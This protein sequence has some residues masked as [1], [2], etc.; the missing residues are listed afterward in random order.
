MEGI[1]P[2]TVRSFV[3]EYGSIG[4]AH[5]VAI[6]YN[7]T[8]KAG[9]MVIADFLLSPA[10]QARKGDEA[11]WGAPT[12]LAYDKLSTQDQALFDAAISGP[13]TLGE[14]ELVATL[15]EPHALWSNALDAEWAKRYGAG[16]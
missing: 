6:P 4:N 15:N 8:A 2:D 16:N 5:F 11:V 9:A 10:A 12:V 14:Q 1:L 13:A 7:A 3:M